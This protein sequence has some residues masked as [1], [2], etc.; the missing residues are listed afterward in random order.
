MS[1][2]PSTLGWPHLLM[3]IPGAG[4]LAVLVMASSRSE[5][6]E[7][8][9]LLEAARWQG[10]AFAV[11]ALHAALQ[12]GIAFVSWLFASLPPEFA[13]ASPLYEHLPLLLKICTHG[14]VTAFV[15][16]W[17]VLLWFAVRASRGAPYP[18]RGRSKS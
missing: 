6:G 15:A 1:D 9:E 16:E 14:N 7:R 10:G 2:T 13:D 18:S 8:A 5:E 11:F 3:L 4:A 17:G 12:L